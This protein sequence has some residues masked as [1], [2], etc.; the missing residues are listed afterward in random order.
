MLRRECDNLSGATKRQRE[1]RQYYEVGVKLDALQATDA[2]RCKAVVVLQAA[3]LPLHGDAAAVE[4][5]ELVRVSLE[6]GSSF[7]EL[8]SRARRAVGRNLVA[9]REVRLPAGRVP[10]ATGAALDAGEQAGCKGSQLQL[11]LELC[12]SRARSRN[13]LQDPG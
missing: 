12:A 8:L 7:V 1:S 5:T 2:K 13:D 4:A 3:E 9:G 6:P 10:V 11:P